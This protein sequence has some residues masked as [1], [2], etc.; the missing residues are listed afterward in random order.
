VR[1]LWQKIR[2]PQSPIRNRNESRHRDSYKDGGAGFGLL[3]SLPRK[4]PYRFLDPAG[5]LSAPAGFYRVWLQ[6]G[7]SGKNLSHSYRGLRGF[8]GFNWNRKWHGKIYKIFHKKCKANR[9]VL[10][11]F[12]RESDGKTILE[13]GRCFRPA[14]NNKQNWSQNMETKIIRDCDSF[15]RSLVFW[16]TNSADIPAT[17]DGAK[18]VAKLGADLDQL[19]KLGARQKGISVAAQNALVLGLDTELE[20][21]ATTADAVAEDVPGF[22]DLFRRPKHVTPHEVL[23]TAAVFLGQLA[24]DADDDA[25]TAA[26][27]TARLQEFTSHGH[28][29]TLVADLQDK[30]AAIGTVSGT[31]EQSRETGVGSTKAIAELVRDG[32]KQLKH[33]DALAKN[34]YKNSPEKLRAWESARHVEHAPVRQAATPTPAPATTSTAK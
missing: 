4:S 8:D 33:L 32:K 7:L 19:D 20:N 2:N 23:A 13:K 5:M 25:A 3:T 27:K 1:S 22:N 28:A 29:A 34:V 31:H 11:Q 10:P 21:M 15:D 30:V 18:Y 9:A 17:S 16:K 26:A 14:I 12:G 24:P 6:Q